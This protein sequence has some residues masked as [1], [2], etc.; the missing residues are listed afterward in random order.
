V[1]ITDVQ[2]VEL[3]GGQTAELLVFDLPPD[4][5]YVGA[6]EVGMPAFVT[7]ARPE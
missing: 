2:S 5:N 1:K 4:P 3:S 7:C 6:V